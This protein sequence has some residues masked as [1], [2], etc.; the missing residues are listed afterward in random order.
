MSVLEM[1]KTFEAVNH[2]K[3]PYR[4]TDRRPG[5]IA[6]C[7]ADTSLANQLLDWKSSLTLTDMCRDA[8]NWQISPH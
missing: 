6:R 2:C 4:I 1:I 3:V 5:D 8:W 7:W